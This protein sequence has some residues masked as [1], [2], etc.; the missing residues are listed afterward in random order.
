[1]R[2]ESC[3]VNTEHGRRLG[4]GVVRAHAANNMDMAARILVLCRNKAILI[5]QLCEVMGN[6]LG[7]YDRERGSSLCR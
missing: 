1:M 4:C 2:S 3:V 5:I 7:I 6:G